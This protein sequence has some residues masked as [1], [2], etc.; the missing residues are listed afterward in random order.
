VAGKRQHYLPQFLQRGFSTIIGGRK[1][2]LYRKNVAPREVGFRDVGVEE[3]FYNLE[4]DSSVDELIT[5][6]EREEFVGVIEKARSAPAGDFEAA[7]TVATLIAHL[8]V[9][10]RHLRITFAELARRAWNDML[11]YFD[12]PAIAAAI[13]RKHIA[14]TPLN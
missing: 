10:S 14:Q 7:E 1:T 8:E 6:I 4:G 11:E 5:E 12:D 2:W 9:R 3:N 13:V